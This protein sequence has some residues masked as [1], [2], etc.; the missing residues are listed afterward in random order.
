MLTFYVYP[1]CQT[2][3]NALDVHLLEVHLLK[4]LGRV[5]KPRISLPVPYPA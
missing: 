3:I 4:R 1:V 5:S 2:V